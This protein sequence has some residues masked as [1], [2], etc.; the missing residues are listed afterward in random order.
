MPSSTSV[1]PTKLN[2]NGWSSS[3][4]SNGGSSSPIKPSSGAASRAGTPISTAP[5]H[6]NGKST[7]QIP[8]GCSHISTLLQL[9]ASIKAPPSPTKIKSEDGDDAR[10]SFDSLPAAT[11][12]YLKRYI[13]GLR[14]GAQ[15]R[16]GHVK[17]MDE[18]E[19]EAELQKWNEEVA[20]ASKQGKQSKKRRKVTVAHLPSY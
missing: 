8:P 2:G 16:T 13:A 18:E 20:K 6:H 3:Q 14:W 10:S 15:I 4:R 11:R 1:S 19:K 9:D 5:I 12:S 7:R 17:M